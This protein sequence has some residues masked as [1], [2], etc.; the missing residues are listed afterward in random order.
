MIDWFMK[1]FDDAGF[2]PR[3]NC[4][5]LIEEPTLVETLRYADL[6]IWLA[7][8]A[9]P[10][11]LLVFVYRKRTVPFQPIFLLF[12][13]F[14]ISCGFT[15]FV[16]ALLIETPMYRLSAAVKVLTAAVSWLTVVALIPTVPKALSL[17]TPQELEGEIAQ[18]IEAQRQ[19]EQARDELELRVRERTAELEREVAE[20]RRVQ[21]EREQ[22]LEREMAARAEAVFANRTKDEFLATLSH[23]LRTP[24][25]AM[26]GWVQLMRT[27]RLDPA[28]MQRG[29]EVLENNTRMQAQLIDDLLDV[30]RIISGKMVMERRSML[31]QE[32][33]QGAL[34]SVRLSAEAKGVRL[35]QEGEAKFAILGDPTRV[36]QI[37][38]NLL[39]NAVK[40]TP[41]GGSVTLR[42]YVEAHQVVLE[43]RDTGE[44]IP[45]EVLPHIFERFRQADSSITRKHGGLGLGLAIVKHLVE[46]HGGQ[47]SAH[48][49]GP[50]LGAVFTLRLPMHQASPIALD[51]QRPQ[52]EDIKGLRILVV[53]DSPDTLE[54]L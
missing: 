15:H 14:I 30:S 35:V 5:R 12:G 2:I 39:S 16:D 43:V 19:L 4:G 50:G 34:D 40:F 6:A 33:I 7:Y 29:L 13:A 53:E 11:I 22:L 49:D 47:I 44:G 45:P 41:R 28:M 48:S 54:L 25:N 52:L 26:L 8:L 37:L 32:A 31:L 23:E 46:L 51:K 10:A 17:R 3:R 1:L 27:G 42:T 18:R 36:Q 21:E 20:R 9:I 38:W 24:L